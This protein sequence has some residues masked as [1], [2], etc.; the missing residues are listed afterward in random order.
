MTSHRP[1]KSNRLFL[2]PNP[3]WKRECASTWYKNSPV[4]QNQISKWTRSAAQ[5]IGLSTDTTKI[6]N[7]SIRATAIL[8]LAKH[9]IGETQM[10]KIGGH[11]STNSLKPYLQLDKN[12]HEQIISELRGN[13]SFPATTSEA[14][15]S[16]MNDNTL[17]VRYNN[18]T[19]NYNFK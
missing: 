18:C 17:G 14:G 9:G 10:I 12:H 2:T 19:M 11:S 8:H 1:D 16:G 6:S 5:A 3:K 4:G 7:H 13:T 15:P